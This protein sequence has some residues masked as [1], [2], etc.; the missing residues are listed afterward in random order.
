MFNIIMVFGDCYGFL[1]QFVG[2]IIENCDK[3]FI[4]N[5]VLKFVLVFFVKYVMM[6][7]EVLNDVFGDCE[8]ILC[9]DE[10][11]EGIV[12]FQISIYDMEYL[13][14]FEYDIEGELC[15]LDVL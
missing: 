13:F 15:D 2:E 6:I 12:F 7:Y 4:F 5:D 3:L 14:G 10:Y 1:S 11:I 9:G 8:D